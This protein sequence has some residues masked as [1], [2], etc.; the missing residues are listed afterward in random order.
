M[1]QFPFFVLTT[2]CAVPHVAELVEHGKQVLSFVEFSTF[3]PAPFV[4]NELNATVLQF[5]DDPEHKTWPVLLHIT[6]P[7]V[8]E[9]QPPPVIPWASLSLIGRPTP[10]SVPQNPRR[11]AHPKATA[12]QRL[13]IERSLF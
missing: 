10:P 9:L 8:H 5:T 11:A 2:M 7:D 1:P 4:I 12:A 3:C 13:F 6:E